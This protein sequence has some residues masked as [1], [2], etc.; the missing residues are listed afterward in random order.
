MLAQMLCPG[1]GN[2][3]AGAP[4]RCRLAGDETTLLSGLPNRQART[5]RTPGVE[6]FTVGT[7]SCSDPFEEIESR[8][9]AGVLLTGGAA[10]AGLGLASGGAPGS[11]RSCCG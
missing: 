8:M 6:D 2:R 9:I 10:I 7:W 3:D 1:G 4:F 11:P 5:R